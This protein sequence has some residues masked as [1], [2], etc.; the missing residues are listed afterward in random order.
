MSARAQSRSERSRKPGMASSQPTAGGRN[1]LIHVFDEY[2][3]QAKD[4]VCQRD[5]LLSKM[6]YFQ[7]YLNQSNEN[8]EIDISV[9]CDVEVFEWLVQYM[10]QTDASWRPRISM[11]NIASILVS[12]E[13]LQMDALVEECIQ[14]I[15]SQMQDFLQLRVD[16]GC[17]SESTIARIAQR[18]SAEELEQL[19]D[20]KDKILSKLQRRKLDNLVNALSDEGRMLKCEQCGVLYLREHSDRLICRN[21]VRTIGMHGEL[22]ALHRARLEW[23]LRDFVQDLVTEKQISWSAAFWYV[24]ASTQCFRCSSCKQHFNLLEQKRCIFHPG[25]LTTTAPDARYSCC[26]AKAFHID[27]FLVSGCKLRDH[28]PAITGSSRS[29]NKELGSGRAP[30]NLQEI[31]NMCDTTIRA[32]S[33]ATRDNGGLQLQTLFEWPE[34]P[35]MSEVEACLAMHVKKALSDCPSPRRRRQWRALQLQEK[36][37]IRVH[38]VTKRLL[39][40]RK[41]LA[42][43]VVMSRWRQQARDALFRCHVGNLRISGVMAR[44]TVQNAAQRWHRPNNSPASQLWAEYMAGTV[45]LSSFYKGQERIKLTMRGQDVHEVYVEAMAAG[46]VRGK[47]DVRDPSATSIPLQQ[48]EMQVA[49]IL[50]GAAKPYTTSIRAIGVPEA[51]WQSFYDVSEQVPTIVRINSAFDTEDVSCCGLTIQKMPE[52]AQHDHQYQLDDLRFQNNEFDASLINNS[53]DL[54]DYL[55]ELIPKADLSEKNCRRVP[56]DFFCRCS[57]KNYATRLQELGREELSKVAME[58]GSAGVDLTCHFCNDAYHFSSG[59][60]DEL[61]SSLPAGNSS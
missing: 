35:E 51:D 57:K 21:S 4:F 5:V 32:A 61:L 25:Q 36:D 3:K 16:F 24:W 42:S 59:E 47:I 31:V 48:G 22:I 6:K 58:M 14:F 10:Q 45:M 18:C 60:L 13:F 12:S 53:S 17:L 1:V 54:M 49:K 11:E 46:E 28:T 56:L 30:S 27:D 52:E 43:S 33:P 44:S 7:A 40:L 39:G 8:D 50:Y 29:L 9:H 26:A 55:N 20:P 41:N 23:N 38:H 15:T 37:R 2:R 34:S 19:H